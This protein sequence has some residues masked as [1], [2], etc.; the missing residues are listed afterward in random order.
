[1]DFDQDLSSEFDRVLDSFCSE[2]SI[3]DA[4]ISENA[5]TGRGQGS[6]TCHKGLQASC[7]EFTV[8]LIPRNGLA[9][10]PIVLNKPHII[11]KLIKTLIT[12]IQKGRRAGT[13]KRGNLNSAIYQMLR[14]RIS[15]MKSRYDIQWGAFYELDQFVKTHMQDLLKHFEK[16]PVEKSHSLKSFIGLFSS[17]IFKRAYEL[18]ISFLFADQN[19]QTRCLIFEFECCNGN[20]V[21]SDACSYNWENFKSMLLRDVLEVFSHKEEVLDSY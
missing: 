15:G 1:M 3:Q 20:D 11:A 4:L 6:V 19:I 8:Q 21:H 2:V 7:N 9:P 14:A 16:Y 18:Y 12:T 17:N 5:N 10:A 13:F